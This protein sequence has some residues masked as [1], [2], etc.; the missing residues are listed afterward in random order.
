RRLLVRRVLGLA[1]RRRARVD[2]QPLLRGREVEA[3]DVAPLGADE[4]LDLARNRDAVLRDRLVERERLPQR[5]V[6]HGRPRLL[7]DQGL[8]RRRVALVDVVLLLERAVALAERD[9]GGGDAVAERRRRVAA[10]ARV[11]G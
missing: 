1:E 11:A 7:D 8:V 2:R 10:R 5:G 9:H 4:G 3:L 6:V